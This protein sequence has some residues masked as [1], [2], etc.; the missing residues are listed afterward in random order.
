MSH[1]A[2][3]A[4][5]CEVMERNSVARSLGE[6]D[7]RFGR[8]DDA[9]QKFDEASRG[10][11]SAGADFELAITY[12]KEAAASCVDHLDTEP[13][14]PDPSVATRAAYCGRKAWFLFDK[15]ELPK[16]A[17]RAQTVIDDL[18][19]RES[20]RRPVKLG[21][22]R[23]GQGSTRSPMIAVST[24]MKRVQRL[25]DEYA[26][27]PDPVLIMGETG[28]GK[29][30]VARRIHEHGCRKTSP[31]VVVNCSAIPADLFEREF[32]GHA[33]GAFTGAGATSPGYVDQAH[34]GTLFLDEIGDMPLPLQSK[35]LR[36]IENS[37]YYR[38][39][40]P[41]ERR[42]NV[43]VIAATN[44][45][46]P[47]LV[48][49]KSFRAD[50]YYRLRLVDIRIPPLRERPRD[51][52]PL[53]ELFLGHMTGRAVRAVECLEP[54]ELDE[55]MLDPLRGNARDLMYFAR[56]SMINKRLLGRL[57]LEAANQ[58][59]VRARPT[60]SEIERLVQRFDGNKA[61]LA[62][63]FGVAR[64]TLYRWLAESGN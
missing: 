62:R 24:A 16:W 14:L 64:S 35:L 7:L 49:E 18:A 44:A 55:L 46:L 20:A 56:R 27:L 38:L 36:L 19:R 11:A 8:R 29:E 31:M 59:E 33:Q 28:T 52:I 45:S 4:P 30:L 58:P 48:S 15:L 32:F 25:A 43:R 50:L 60:R 63:H 57:A 23:R 17:D 51:I 41:V 42:A 40:D 21:R 13:W 22:R 26:S 6:L 37:S 54:H 9:A 47:D 5:G 10:F 34:G 2:R 1:G 12:L 53:L 61:K 3:A 39:G